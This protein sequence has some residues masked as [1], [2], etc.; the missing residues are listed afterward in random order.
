MRITK[1]WL[2]E[3]RTRMGVVIDQYC[4]LSNEQLLAVCQSL[5][6]GVTLTPNP[7]S[8]KARAE[9]LVIA[10]KGKLYTDIPDYMV[11]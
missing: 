8:T 10:L 11:E 3:A 4:C 9:M 6:P 5:Y 2:R 1:K 7:D